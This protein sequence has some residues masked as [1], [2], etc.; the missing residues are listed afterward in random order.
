MVNLRLVATLG[1]FILAISTTGFASIQVPSASNFDP[2]E[3][4]D[5]NQRLKDVATTVPEFGGVFIPDDGATLNIY[6]TSN[7]DDEITQQNAKEAFEEVFGARPRARLVVHQG[8]YNMVEL[9]EWYALMLD[10][11]WA[12]DGVTNT[13]ISE[14]RNRVNI[15]IDDL[16]N[17]GYIVET[18]DKLGIPVAAVIIEQGYYPTKDHTLRDRADNDIMEGGYQITGHDVGTC[19]MRF[20]VEK[21]GDAG[22]ITAGHCTEDVW[23][24]ADDNVRFYQPTQT[25]A[26][27]IGSESIDPE[28]SASLTGCPNNHVCRR[29]DSAFIALDSDVDYNLG[30]IAKPTSLGSTVVEH[31][32]VFRITDERNAVQF[33]DVE[34]ELVNRVG[35]TG[36]WKEGNISATCEVRLSSPAAPGTLARS[37]TCQNDYQVVG[38]TGD[39]GAPVF[40]IPDDTSNDVDLLGI[41]WGRYT[42]TDG[43]SQAHSVYSPI[44]NVYLD[45]DSLATWDACASGFDC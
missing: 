19:T 24:G 17:R 3:Y 22:F 6:L 14:G 9:N 27:G 11:I 32:E 38:W 1:V 42:P 21:D 26:N 13:G 39:S 45:L 44:G 16:A 37:L 29:S 4:K 8:L 25:T 30:Y 41:H 18:L 43:S 12:H 15:G 34:Q 2:A 20:L 40:C 7:K 10:A 5:H 36:G 33:D 31:N 35:R 28:F 23:D